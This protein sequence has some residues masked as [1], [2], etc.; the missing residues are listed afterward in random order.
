M[1]VVVLGSLALE[2]QFMEGFEQVKREGSFGARERHRKPARSHELL[3]AF[4]LMT[5]V[6]TVAEIKS[7][8]VNTRC[9]KKTEIGRSSERKRASTSSVP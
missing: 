2:C 3:P 4:E 6:S 5:L 8:K 1:V 7:N 9:I